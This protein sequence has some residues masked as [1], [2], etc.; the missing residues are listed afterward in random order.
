MNA[1]AAITSTTQE[2]VVEEVLPPAPEGIWKDAD[3]R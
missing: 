1:T 3:H 2:I